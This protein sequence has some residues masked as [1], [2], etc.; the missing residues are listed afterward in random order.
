MVDTFAE[1]L[2]E[3]D[4]AVRRLG[5]SPNER[6]RARTDATNTEPQN[7]AHDPPKVQHP[8]HELDKPRTYKDAANALGVPYHVVQRAA[9]R[10]LVPVHHL[11]SSRRYVTLRDF[12]KLMNR[13]ASR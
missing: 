8:I 12:L 2:L 9:R 7:M 13:D 6:P 4:T 11:G 1:P 10:G 3:T 5:V